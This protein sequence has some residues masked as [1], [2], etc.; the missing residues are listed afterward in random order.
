MIRCG[1]AAV[2]LL[3]LLLS[4]CFGRAASSPGAP[5]DEVER[6][7]GALATLSVENATSHR[8]RISFRPVPRPGSE[9][10]IG[11]VPAGATSTLAPIPAEEPI[12]LSAIAEDSS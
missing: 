8:L 12:V 6:H 7:R 4:A 10:T 2:P 3:L 9:V 11:E 1:R 5:G